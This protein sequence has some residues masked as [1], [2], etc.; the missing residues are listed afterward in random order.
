MRLRKRPATLSGV[1]SIKR[2]CAKLLL[3]T[4]RSLVKFSFPPF[5]STILKPDLNGTNKFIF[6]FWKL[7][8]MPTQAECGKIYYDKNS[9]SNIIFK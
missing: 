6:R 2:A 4:N 5:G 3:T 9:S 1:M 7:V 8:Y